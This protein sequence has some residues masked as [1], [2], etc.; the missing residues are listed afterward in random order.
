M[1]AQV[2]AVTGFAVL[3]RLQAQPLYAEHDQTI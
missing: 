1:V 2:F 3:N